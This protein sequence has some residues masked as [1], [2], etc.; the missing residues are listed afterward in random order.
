MRPL[1]CLFALPLLLGL[2]G[3]VAAVA[4]GAVY[5][6]VKYDG[7]EAMRDFDASVERVWRA[8]LDAL[9]GRGYELP[10][11]VSRELAERQDT[12]EATGDGYWLRVE[13]QPEKRTRVRVRIGTFN[14]DE[15]KR[16]AA[17]LI[18]SIA[19]RL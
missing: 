14:T 7:N 19:D 3:C 1:T 15:H 13:E 8:S 12:A 4:A 6:I 16:K 9:E 18:E 17:L 10:A 5:G 11:G 2:S